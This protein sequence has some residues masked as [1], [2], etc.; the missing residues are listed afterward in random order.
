MVKELVM[1]SRSS[2]C[3]FVSL[4][5]RVLDDYQVPYR[6][7]Y[8][9][10]DDEARQ[11]VL[12]WTGFLSVPTLIVAQPGEILPFEPQTSLERGRSPRGIDRGSMITEPSVDDLTHWL[13]R[14]GFITEI[15]AD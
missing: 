12:A 3:P 5:K 10:R 9:D 15:A 8:I 14:N 2:S 6:E 11:R 4:A 13:Q 7:V 1:Y